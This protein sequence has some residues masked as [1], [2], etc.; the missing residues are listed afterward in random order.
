MIGETLIKSKNLIS[1]YNTELV[2]CYPGKAPGAKGDRSPTVQEIRTCI[3]KRFFIQELSLIRPKLLI[4]MG[5]LSRNAFY[6][7]ILYKSY[8]ENLSVHINQIIETEIP[9]EKIEN[10]DLYILPIQ[11][12]SGANPEF[13]KMLKNDKLIALIDKIIN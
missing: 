9:R 4:L 10:N 8:P 12:A 11:H 13:Q 5:R 7:Y 6:Q 2:Q 1:V 3:G